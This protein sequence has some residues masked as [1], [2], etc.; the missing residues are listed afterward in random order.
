M[1]SRENS[2][3]PAASELA[4]MIYDTTASSF[5]PPRPAFLR[6]FRERVTRGSIIAVGETHSHLTHH[7]VQLELLRSAHQFSRNVALGGEMFLSEHQPF[8]DAYVSGAMSMRTLVRKLQWNSTWGYDIKLYAPLLRFCRLHQIPIAGLNISPAIASKV[9]KLGLEGLSDA[10]RRQLPELDL[11]NAE[12]LA[13]FLKIMASSGFVG[14]HGGISMEK[15]RSYYH[16]KVLWDEHMAEKASRFAIERGIVA[17]GPD[18]AYAPAGTFLLLCGS[19]HV[20]NR[21]GVPDRIKRRIGIDPFVVVPRQVEFDRYAQPVIAQLPDRSEA[22][23]IWYGP[24]EIDL[25]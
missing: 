23:W 7:K 13:D 18:G 20:E 1:A 14:A 8:L 2:V 16:V 17:R 21:R 19:A 24:R 5:L 12:H 15:L 9:G 25:V 11:D 6:R 10:E 22:D 4:G 3:A